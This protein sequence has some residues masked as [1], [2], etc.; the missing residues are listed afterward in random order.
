TETEPAP[1]PEGA[2]PVAAVDPAEEE[3]IASSLRIL[4]ARVSAKSLAGWSQAVLPSRRV[5]DLAIE[6]A[7]GSPEARCELGRW[8]EARDLRDCDGVAE[9]LLASCEAH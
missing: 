4:C 5:L 7:R 9:G 3:Q 2:P 6:V 1:V 8:M